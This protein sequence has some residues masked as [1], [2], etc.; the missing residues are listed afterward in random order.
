VVN[1]GQEGLERIRNDKF[2]LILLD[3]AMPDF[4]GKDVIESLKKDELIE[5]TNIVI[6]TA[7][8]SGD[9]KIITQ[10]VSWLVYAPSRFSESFII[11]GESFSESCQRVTSVNTL[12]N[13]PKALLDEI[14]ATEERIHLNHE[15]TFNA[16][17]Q[18]KIDLAK[19]I[20]RLKILY[21][22]VIF[23]TRD[24]FEI[25]AVYF[26]SVFAYRSKNII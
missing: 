15:T 9:R 1:D 25:Q 26:F 24:T 18:N 12:N 21:E 3:V 10:L 8:P 5:S 19:Q 22:L 4:S 16:S 23:G 2:D 13:I 6:F 17:M 14:K 7:S 11:F 20:L